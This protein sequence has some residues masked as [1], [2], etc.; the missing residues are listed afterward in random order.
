MEDALFIRAQHCFLLYNSVS[1]VCMGTISGAFSVYKDNEKV[2]LNMGPWSFVFELWPARSP[3]FNP[4]IFI[5]GG[6]FKVMCM[7]R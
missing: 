7:L 5:Y 4:L 2:C 6:T 3:D 1:E